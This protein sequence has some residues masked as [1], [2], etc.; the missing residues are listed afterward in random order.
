MT[1]EVLE[2]KYDQIIHRNRKFKTLD[3]LIYS[4][5]VPIS[6]LRGFLR[7][8][9]DKTSGTKKELINRIFL[10]LN[11]D[12][13]TLLEQVIPKNLLLHIQVRKKSKKKE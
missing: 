6:K 12:M 4:F 1:S 13:Y 3:G 9:Y 8:N 2:I 5:L 7:E 10:N 11:Y